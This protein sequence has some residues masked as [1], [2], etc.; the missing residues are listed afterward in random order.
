MLIDQQTPI[1]VGLGITRIESK[2]ATK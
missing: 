2:L 1:A